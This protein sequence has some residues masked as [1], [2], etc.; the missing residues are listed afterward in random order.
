M[1][2]DKQPIEEAFK[3]WRDLIRNVQAIKL[4][5]VYSNDSTSPEL[6]VC[7]EEA[8]KK[9]ITEELSFVLDEKFEHWVKCDKEIYAIWKEASGCHA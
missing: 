6:A 4:K 9:K 7:L 1:P 5:M 2:I 3:E 8:V